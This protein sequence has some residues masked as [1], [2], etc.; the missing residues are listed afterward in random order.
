MTT[1]NF[2]G[3]GKITNGRDFN[4]YQKITV[5]ATSF[6]GNAVDGVQP[7]AIITFSTQTVMFLNEDATNVVEYSLNGTTVHGELDPTKP[8]KGLT[9]DNRPISCIWFRVK[10][11]SAPGAIIRI[12]AWAR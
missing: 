4:Y 7:D 9:F 6:G 10:S 11:G 5:T 12:D 2:P 1:N 3:V 8:S